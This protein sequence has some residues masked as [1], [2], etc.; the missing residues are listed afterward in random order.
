MV[1]WSCSSPVYKGRHS[2]VGPTVQGP[3]GV[4]T[5]RKSHSLACDRVTGTLIG[6]LVFLERVQ[7]FDASV[8]HYYY[9]KRQNST[10]FRYSESA[11]KNIC[12]LDWF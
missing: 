6:Y 1:R 12:L 5:R 3:V 10:G 4:G 2:V 7:G 8:W 9:R 11:K